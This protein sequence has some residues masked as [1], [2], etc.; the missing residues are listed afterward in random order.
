MRLAAFFRGTYI[1]APDVEFEWGHRAD[2]L[3]KERLKE[4]SL[5]DFGLET[6]MMM[7]DYFRDI[8]NDPTGD[9]RK[10]WGENHRTKVMCWCVGI[11]ILL[12]LRMIKDDAENG[13]G[14]V[15]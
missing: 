13:W 6:M 1:I 10:C 9:S 2:E 14:M 12:R 3:I 8:Q 4:I 7:N 15:E 5:R 11:S